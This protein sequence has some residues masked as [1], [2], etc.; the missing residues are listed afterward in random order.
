[1]N[2]PGR[3]RSWSALAVCSRMQPSTAPAAEMP[4][5][6]RR[7]EERFH[8]VVDEVDVAAE[9]LIDLLKLVGAE[10]HDTARAVLIRYR[11]TSP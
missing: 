1:M 9:E 2:F 8:K 4:L 11:L 6:A 7:A 3:K 5:S 10:F